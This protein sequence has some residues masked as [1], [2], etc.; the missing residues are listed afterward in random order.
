MSASDPSSR[1]PV[2][3][4]E[5]LRLQELEAC[6]ILDT[7]PEPA[8]DDLVD[9]A[10]EVANVP[11][12]LVSLVD[13]QRQWFKARLGLEATQTPRDV[14][15][16]AHAIAGDGAFIVSDARQDSR[17]TDNPLV[18]GHPNVVFYAGFPLQSEGQ[19]LGTLCVIDYEPRELRPRQLQ[20][21]Q[22]LKRQV[23]AQIQ[24]RKR[25]RELDET[26]ES[27]A[28]KCS[29][30]EHIVSSISHDL[31]EPL[32]TVDSFIRLFLEEHGTDLHGEARQYLDFAAEGARRG[33]SMIDSLLEFWRARSTKQATSVNLEVVADEVCMDLSAVIGQTRAVISAKPL[34]TIVG[35]GPLLRQLLQNLIANALKYRSSAPPMV[36]VL[37]EQQGARWVLSVVDNGAGIPKDRLDHIFDP[38]Y[39]SDAR[40]ANGS[41][42][43]LAIA[44][45]IVQVHGGDIWV[46]RTGM[47][48]TTFQ[49][50]LP[51]IREPEIAA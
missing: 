2:L 42:M 49:I 47:G 33:K 14:A 48:G 39:T 28:E 35:H 30:L 21:L 22:K 32:R 23:E 5:T 40:G 36:D 4:D 8:F 12:A 37:C 25:V 1:H 20:A 31:Q 10:A 18:C 51:I 17:F 46:E 38:F 6:Q 19:R 3:R 7:D 45:R 44:K 26:R 27:L 15:F 11:I 43:G 13:A 41:G 16:C 50:S 9:L 34:P 24:L 29:Q